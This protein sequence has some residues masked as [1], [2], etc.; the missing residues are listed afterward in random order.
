MSRP[1]KPPY[2]DILAALRGLDREIT[3]SRFK[4]DVRKD[5]SLM[6]AQAYASKL[7]HQY[8]HP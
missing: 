8:D 7:L 5:F 1:S 2:D 6:N 4:L 3:A